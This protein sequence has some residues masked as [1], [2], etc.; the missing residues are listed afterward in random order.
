MCA[1]KLQ[2]CLTLCDGMDPMEPARLLC[3]WD[4]PG[5]NTGVSYPD[6]PNA[7]I[8]L[9]SPVSPVLQ[10]DSLPTEPPAG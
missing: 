2:S 4:S 6:L 5:K 7:G 1:Q 8:K 10:A 9:A 3:L